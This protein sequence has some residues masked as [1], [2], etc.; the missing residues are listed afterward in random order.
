M[1][2]LVSAEGADQRVTQEIQIAD[3][4]QHLVFNELVFVT[5]TIVIQNPIFIEHDGVIEAAAARQ[6]CRA[7]RLEIAHETESARTAD[8]SYKRGCGKVDARVLGRVA[9]GRMIEFDGDRKSTR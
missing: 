2:G 7:Q 3:S 4:I 6:S 1:P 9:E 5:Q 8:F